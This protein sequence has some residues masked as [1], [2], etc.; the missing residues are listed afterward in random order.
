MNRWYIGYELKRSYLHNMIL[1][2][3]IVLAMIGGTA[4]I[5]VLWP[6]TADHQQTPTAR[7][8]YPPS[9]FTFSGGRP[10]ISECR[11][12]SAR[13][14]VAP[15]PVLP[16]TQF[17]AGYIGRVRIVRDYNSFVSVPVPVNP[18]HQLCPT[19]PLV[20]SNAEDHQESRLGTG[21]GNIDGHGDNLFGLPPTKP[22]MP[23][24]LNPFD[25]HTGLHD[26]PLNRKA[27]LFLHPASWPARA[28]TFVPRPDSGVVW[29]T[30]LLDADGTISFTIDSTKPDGL[31]FTTAVEWSMKNSRY[32]PAI[33]NGQPVPVG[34]TMT[35][36]IRRNGPIN[37]VQSS[38]GRIKASVAD[39]RY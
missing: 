10:A 9:E 29:L 39:P 20:E 24:S 3:L 30:C 17:P 7:A 12:V 23:L 35:Y 38:N 4:A 16:G 34:F 22:F 11:N 21:S 19:Q 14:S 18:A 37:W 2:W 13:S 36:I 26:I 28:E 27:N 33:E 32:T 1:S 31:G 5:L 15:V 6:T 8:D 25:F